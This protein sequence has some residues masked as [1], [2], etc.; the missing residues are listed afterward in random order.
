MNNLDQQILE[1][2]VYERVK[3]AVDLYD[4]L[5]F[6]EDLD[7]SIQRALERVGEQTTVDEHLARKLID[8]AWD[9]LSRDLDALREVPE[10]DCELCRLDP[11]RVEADIAAAWKGERPAR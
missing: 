7:Q 2:L 8:A 5:S 6:E 10:P 9:R 11:A 3:L 4:L 1:E